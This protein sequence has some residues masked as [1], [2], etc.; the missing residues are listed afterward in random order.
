[1]TMVPESARAREPY[2]T[3]RQALQHSGRGVVAELMSQ[4]VPDG[5]LAEPVA[6]GLEFDRRHPLISL[7]EFH[8]ALL[9]E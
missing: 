8:R 9:S 7:G 2:V 5:R 1:M 3:T 4:R 6:E